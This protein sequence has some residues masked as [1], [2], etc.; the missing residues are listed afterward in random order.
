[1]ACD[2]STL[3][4]DACDNGFVAVAQNE[5]QYRAVLLQLLCNMPDAAAMP[6]LGEGGIPIFGEDGPIFS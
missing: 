3:Q 2:I 6:I 5:Q 1:M 4:S